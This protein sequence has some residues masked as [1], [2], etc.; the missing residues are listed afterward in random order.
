MKRAVEEHGLKVRSLQGKIETYEETIKHMK[1]K[2]RSQE[3]KIIMLQ[4][5]TAGQVLSKSIIRLTTNFI[6]KF[7]KQFTHLLQPFQDVDDIDDQFD[8][9]AFIDGE[10]S[11]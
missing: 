3:E 6:P 8:S 2:I 5:S 4:T 1:A 9:S 10:A 11:Q 7:F